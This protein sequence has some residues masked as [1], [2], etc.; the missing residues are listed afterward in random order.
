M[1][2]TFRTKLWGTLSGTPYGY[3]IGHPSLRGLFSGLNYRPHFVG[4]NGHPCG[5][6]IWVPFG[7]PFL[8]S[9]S[10]IIAPSGQTCSMWAPTCTHFARFHF[11][12]L[13]SFAGSC[14]P[15]NGYPSGTHVGTP[16]GYPL[17]KTKII[18]FSPEPIYQKKLGT[19]ISTPIGHPPNEGN[20]TPDLL[21][22]NQIRQ[23]LRHILLTI[24]TPSTYLGRGVGVRGT[25]RIRR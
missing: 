11:V 9:T 1:R 19:H 2:V 5:A 24:S 25:L 6:P 18:F 4:L 17:L 10:L 12:I 21:D 22:P 20:L 7:H 3:P 16:M 14:G 15:S 13:F 23:L 8:G